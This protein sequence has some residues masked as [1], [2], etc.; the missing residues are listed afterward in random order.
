MTEA[1]VALITGGA[2]GIGWA[3]AR[4]FAAGG[5]RVAIADVRKEAAEQAAARLGAGHLAYGC[6]VSIEHD[7]RGCLDALVA[8]AG[9]LDV[10]VNNAGI[11]SAHLPTLS[12]AVDAFERVLRIHLTGTFQV[13]REAARVMSERG[14][15]IVNLSSI[16]GVVGL[17]RRNAY[18][19]AKA[20]V[21]AMTRSMACEWARRGIRVNAVAPGF[22]ATA[23]VQKLEQGGSI[24]RRRIESRIPMGRMARPEEIAEAIFFLASPMASYITGT[25]LGVDGG[26][27]AFGDAGP[28]YEHDSTDEHDCADDRPS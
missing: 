17:P 12:Q 19:A 6:D 26:W 2:D 16:A 28:A 5:Y 20:G 1:P 14:G 18:G 24:D 21:I 22:T 7:V 4:R 23:L 13:S 11:G 10:L 27:A 9:R 15:A 3:A 25:V 8:E